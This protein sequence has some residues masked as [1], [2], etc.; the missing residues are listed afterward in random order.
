[1]T[2][3]IDIGLLLFHDLTQL[4]LTAP[5]EVFTRVPGARVHLLAKTPAAVASEH[6]LVIVPTMTLRDARRLDVV[7]VSGEIGARFSFRSSM[8]PRPHSIADRRASRIPRW[9]NAC[10]PRRLPARRSGDASSSELRRGCTM[11]RP[12]GT[13]SR[14]GDVPMATERCVT[15]RHRGET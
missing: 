12:D 1:M 11:R 15:H 7:C 4:D 6:G 3:P 9:S 5:Y 2:D 8:T 10:A 14:R 13:T